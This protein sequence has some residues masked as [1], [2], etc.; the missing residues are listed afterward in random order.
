M[1]EP[2]TKETVA[3]T[4]THKRVA[5]LAAA[6]T[7]FRVALERNPKIVQTSGGR[8]EGP[9]SHTRFP[10]FSFSRLLLF[11]F[12]VG[13]IF[14]SF[15]IIIMTTATFSLPFSLLPRSCGRLF[16]HGRPSSFVDSFVEISPP[17]KVS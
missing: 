13:I 2:A 1:I 10:F 9:P 8:Q 12:Y 7:Y 6:V 3:F 11:F 17:P 4:H 14:V 16:G 5:T 15:H